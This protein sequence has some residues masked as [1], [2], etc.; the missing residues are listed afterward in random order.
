MRGL[1]GREGLETERLSATA[2]RM[3]RA[4]HALELRAVAVARALVRDG[5]P[6][7]LEID[8]DGLAGI[9]AETRLR[10]LAGALKWIATSPYRPREHALEEALD[11]LDGGGTVSL[12][13][14]LAI[15][16]GPRLWI[17]REPQAVAETTAPVGGLWDG[18]WR[19]TGP[20]GEVRALGAEGLLAQGRPDHPAPVQV[21]QGLPAVNG[22][23]PVIAGNGEYTATLLPPSGPFGDSLLSH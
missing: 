19:V 15:P 22:S 6:G 18:R 10:L 2:R 13:G 14:C 21:W 8:R 20:G 3:A 5:A 16:R 17:C 23:S 12:H 1:I 4:R 9:E 11:R 7:A